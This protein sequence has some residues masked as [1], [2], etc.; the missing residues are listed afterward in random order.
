MSLDQPDA[1]DAKLTAAIPGAVVKEEIANPQ[2]SRFVVHG[3]NPRAPG[4]KNSQLSHGST[5][6]EAVDRAVHLF[7]SNR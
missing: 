5:R 3:R 7:G 4:R 2:E 6:R 1:I